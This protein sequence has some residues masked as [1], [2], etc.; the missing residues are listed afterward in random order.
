MGN[1]YL[2]LAHLMFSDAEPFTSEPLDKLAQT[3]G[4]NA[5]LNKDKDS[6]YYLTKGNRQGCTA[7]F[8]GTFVFDK[9]WYQKLSSEELLAIGAHEFNH[10]IK[11]HSRQMLFRVFVPAFAVLFIAILLTSPLST[12]FSLFLTRSY[13]MLL[14][15]FATLFL[16]LFTFLGIW[17]LNSPWQRQLETDCDLSAVRFGYGEAM[18]TALTKLRERFPKSKWTIRLIH[19]HPSFEQRVQD[20]RQAMS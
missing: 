6:R 11:K 20:I 4:A 10:I 13:L 5:V 9:K 16:F 3:M 8:N 1:K 15:Q 19:T 17:Y 7:L 14:V 18:I 2:N 12:T